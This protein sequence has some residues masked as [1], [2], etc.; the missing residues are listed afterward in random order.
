MGV[1]FLTR[2]CTRSQGCRLH[3]RPDVGRRAQAR[4]QP[5]GVSSPG[6]FPVSPSLPLSKNPREPI[7]SGEGN[8]ERDVFTY[9][10]E[11]T[12]SLCSVNQK[13]PR[14]CYR[15]SERRLTTILAAMRTERPGGAGG[16]P[17][18]ARSG[19]WVRARS[20]SGGAPGQPLTRTRTG[21]EK[22][23]V[24]D[25]AAKP[26]GQLRVRSLRRPRPFGPSPR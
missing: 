6:C 15:V 16:S 4:R 19:G 3:A 17:A 18:V 7:S 13:R 26:R 8:H 2:A 24:G 9:R 22:A 20:P 12:S 21:T 1:R 25:P 11:P 10:P 5:K 14:S 23:P